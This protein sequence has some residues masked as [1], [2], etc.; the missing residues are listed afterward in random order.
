M[1]FAEP[2]R[3]LVARF[4]MDSRLRGNDTVLPVNSVVI[5]AKAGIHRDRGKKIKAEEPKLDHNN[6]GLH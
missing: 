6:H 2:V 4:S 3:R 1:I 5:P